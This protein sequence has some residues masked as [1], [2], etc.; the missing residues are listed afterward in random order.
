MRVAVITIRIDPEIHLGLLTPNGRALRALWLK[1]KPADPTDPAH[2][3]SRSPRV[4]SRDERRAGGIGDDLD[5][6]RD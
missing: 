4:K 2:P 3:G 1:P 6:S 5:R